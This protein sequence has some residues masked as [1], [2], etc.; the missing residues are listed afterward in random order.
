MIINK[1]ILSLL[2]AMSF[3]SLASAKVEL[4]SLFT[5]NMVLQQQTEA[6]IW[7]KATPN[8]EITI[9]SSWDNKTYKVKA[10]ATGRWKTKLITPKAGGPYTIK[11]SD[12]I[13]II[14]DNVLIGE[15]WVCGGQSNMEMTMGGG[16]KVA[17][18]EEEI[19]ATDY[20]QIR[21]FHVERAMST[22]PQEDFGKTRAG[23]KVCS[24]GTVRQFSAVAYFFARNLYQTLNIPIGLISSS[25]GGTPAEAWTSRNSLKQMSDFG[26]ELEH[27]SS[28]DEKAEQANFDK[29]LQEWE[30]T[31]SKADKGF[32]EKIPIW[33]DLNAIDGN[34][35]DLIFPG[36]WDSQGL[37]DLNGVVWLR[38]TIEI[39]QQ[40]QGKEL[41]L[42]LGKIDDEDI[43]YFNGVQVGKTNNVYASRS[44]KIPAQSVKAGKAMITIRVTDNAGRGGLLGGLNGL[45]L[46]MPNK[47]DFD[48]ISL[49]GNWKYKI[50]VDFKDYAKK[51]KSKLDN[52]NRSTVL[53]NAM[54][55]P[56]I[57]YA[58]KGIIWYQGEANCMKSEQYK[59]LFPLL[60]QDWRKQWGKDLP[61]HFVQLANFGDR[62]NEPEDAPWAQLREAQLETL[63]VDNTTMSVTIDVGEGN[64]VHPINKQDVG[65]RLALAARAKTYNENLSYSGPIYKSYRI[66]G[67]KICISFEHTDNGLVAKGDSQIRGFAIAGAD[68]K[69]YWAEAVIVGNEVVVSSP[70]VEMPLA[71][72]YAWAANPECNLYN[73]VN[74]PASPFRTDRWK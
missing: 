12:G 13:P 28:L 52:P 60:I 39:P 74:L 71:V 68:Q 66:E 47:L 7:G 64:D 62:K 35:G 14:L 53:Y 6:P 55:N 16:R 56:M 9:A 17:N 3:S 61:F 24:P 48:P 10:D 25:V 50:A 51:P 33:A 65:F 5:N 44:Y 4:A 36:E 8:K 70:K 22:E 15:V 26:E 27:L 59:R 40:W 45:T 43:T 32:N 57:N 19:K 42:D 29:E 20:P 46:K 58:V 11:V 63:A 73:G 54:I 18:Y 49:D 72:R 69:F 67:N 38:K 41:L 31:I 30:N 1:K 34:W 21:L 37:A 2:V 23:W